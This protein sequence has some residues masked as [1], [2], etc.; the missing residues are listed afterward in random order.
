MIKP[1]PSAESAGGG[2][3]KINIVLNW[4]EELKSRVPVK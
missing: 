1:P 2:Q 3:R 4:T